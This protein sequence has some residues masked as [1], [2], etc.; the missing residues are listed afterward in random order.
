M[1]IMT[2]GSKHVLCNIN[3]GQAQG[4]NDVESVILEENTLAFK[5]FKGN[6]QQN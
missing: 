1:K 6:L 3:A 4:D 2:H 5:R